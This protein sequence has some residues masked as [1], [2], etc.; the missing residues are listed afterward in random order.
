MPSAGSTSI[1][2]RLCRSPSQRSARPSR[3]VRTG[4]GTF[5]LYRPAC[6]VRLPDERLTSQNLRSLPRCPRKETSIR[7]RQM[8]AAN[9]GGSPR[10]RP[11]PLPLPHSRRPDP[12]Y[13]PP[14]NFLVARVRQATAERPDLPKSERLLNACLCADPHVHSC[15]EADPHPLIFGVLASRQRAERRIWRWPGCL[16][17]LARAAAERPVLAGVRHLVTIQF[18]CPGTGSSSGLHTERLSLLLAERDGGSS[19]RWS[20]GS[21]RPH[22]TRVSW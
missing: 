10:L 16:L 19:G 12:N 18:V 2:V 4:C 9:T 17:F 5:L 22:R 3:Q 14:Q 6:P 21:R 11:R 13:Q 20:T 15:P 7:S 8:G 1:A